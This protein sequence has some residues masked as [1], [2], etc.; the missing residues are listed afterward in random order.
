[1]IK[2]AYVSFE[3]AKLL[4][5]KGFEIDTNKDYWKIG[6]DGT[7]YFM[8]SIGAYTS[9]PNNKLAFYRPENS[10][11]CPTLQMAM[12]WLR[13]KDISIEPS[14]LNAHSWAY[15]IYKLLNNKVKELYNDG[16]FD[17]YEDAVEAALKYC[18]ENLFDLINKSY[19]TRKQT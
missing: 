9:N 13:E 5:E 10:Y 11:P 2:E 14:A 12:A 16:G 7:M 1:M 17:S 3:V 8:C 4:E 6:E 15:T 19:G 18:L